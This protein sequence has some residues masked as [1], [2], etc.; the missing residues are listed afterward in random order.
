MKDMKNLECLLPDTQSLLLELIDSCNFLHKYVLCGGSALALY[1]CHRK[2]EDLDFFT[3]N[4]NFDKTEII[5]YLNSLENTQIINQTSSQIDC[6]ANGVKLTFFNANWSFLKPSKVQRFNLASL[7][8]IAAMKVNVLFLRAKY[9]DY[10]DLYFLVKE[11]MSLKEVFK[12]GLFVMPNITFKLF[13]TALIYVDD[14]EDDI[15]DALDPKERLT[16]N[17]IRDFFQKKLKNY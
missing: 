1:M 11:G 4:G 14:I 6:L 10:Y 5:D 17:D 2:S 15:I 8:S 12:A 3:Y 7:N 9:R 16:K 13:A